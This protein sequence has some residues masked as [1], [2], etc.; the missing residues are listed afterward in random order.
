MGT[1]DIHS[2]HTFGACLL[3]FCVTNH[4]HCYDG[5]NFGVQSQNHMRSS[6]NIHLSKQ[7]MKCGTEVVLYKGVTC[8]QKMLGGEEI[9]AKKCEIAVLGS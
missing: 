2:C 8:F 9:Y 7:K 6:H 1:Q 3:S 4:L 5:L